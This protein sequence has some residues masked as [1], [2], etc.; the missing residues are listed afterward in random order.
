VIEAIIPGLPT[1][2]FEKWQPLLMTQGYTMVY[3]GGV[4]RF[5]LAKE[6]G[7]CANRSR[8]RRIWDDFVTAKQIVQQERIAALEPEIDRLRRRSHQRGSMSERP[9]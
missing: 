6:L 4:N 1:P 2:L 8:S 9:T 7:T 5:Y 3:F